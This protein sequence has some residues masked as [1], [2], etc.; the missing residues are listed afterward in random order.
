MSDGTVLSGRVDLLCNSKM[1][2]RMASLAEEGFDDEI[3]ADF[4]HQMSKR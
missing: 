1:L 4:A 2:D 3:L